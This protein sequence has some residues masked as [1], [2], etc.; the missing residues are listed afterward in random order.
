M[1][2]PTN[3][4]F[5]CLLQ[6]NNQWCG[7]NAG[8][9]PEHNMSAAA[10]NQKTTAGWVTNF[11]HYTAPDSAAEPQSFTQ[12]LLRAQEEERQDLAFE[13]H[14]NLVQSLILIKN[15]ILKLKNNLPEKTKTIAQL[16]T[17]AAMVTAALQ[18]I[19]NITYNLRPYAL[20]LF[21]LTPATQSLLD[22]TAALVPWSLSADLPNLNTVFLKD[23][24]IYIYRI[25]Q[26]CLGII[27]KQPDVS[28]IKLVIF[29]RPTTLVWE[30]YVTGSATFFAYP[31]NNFLKNYALRR[32][33]ELLNLVRG[34]V[35]F[36]A[37]APRITTIQIN[38]PLASA[39][40]T[41]E[42]N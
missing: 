28:N 15:E 1:A 18:N 42:K 2:V 35:T 38:I 30:I 21:G 16:N 5:F 19:R 40:P 26:E 9:V 23:Q 36:T 8:F 34:T 32:V 24:E 12:E 31:S 20:N 14:E 17:L 3:S 13:L 41:H 27:Q 22:E 29:Q 39:P 11:L 10:S 7:Q 37:A 6:T 25:I 33:Q 4:Y